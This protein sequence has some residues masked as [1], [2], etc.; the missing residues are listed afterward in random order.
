M[1]NLLYSQ[2]RYNEAQLSIISLNTYIIKNKDWE[3][4]NQWVES[5]IFEDRE[6]STESAAAF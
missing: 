1:T 2:S 5:H 4:L 6:G 3:K